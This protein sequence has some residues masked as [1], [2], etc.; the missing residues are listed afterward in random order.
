M[1]T[2]VDDLRCNT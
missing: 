1:C 2:F